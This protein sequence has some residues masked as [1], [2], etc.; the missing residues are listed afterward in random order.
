MKGN[1]E[2]TVHSVYLAPDEEPL[3]AIAT[4]RMHSQLTARLQ[5]LIQDLALNDL[6]LALLDLAQLHRTV[7][8]CDAEQL[9]RVRSACATATLDFGLD[10]EGSRR[11]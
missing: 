7:S 8:G 10:T 1:G 9:A 11:E 3:S 6:P 4:D 5:R 2:T